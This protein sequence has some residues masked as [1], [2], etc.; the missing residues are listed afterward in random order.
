MK[1]SEE[2][3]VAISFLIGLLFFGLIA[4][5]FNAYEGYLKAWSTQQD[6]LMFQ[7]AY[8]AALDCRQKVSQSSSSPGSRIMDPDKICGTVPFFTDSVA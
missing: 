2:S 7:K 1:L 3:S 8:E 4:F 6:R 5:S